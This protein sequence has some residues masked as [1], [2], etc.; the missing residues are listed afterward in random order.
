MRFNI[1]NQTNFKFLKKINLGGLKSIFFILSLLYFCIYFFE[2]IDH[3]SFDINLKRNGIYLFLSFLFY[4]IFMFI[5][6]IELYVLSLA[7]V[8]HEAQH[9]LRLLIISTFISKNYFSF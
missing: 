6:I 3:I 9:I 2:N 1:S 7:F 4:R 8:V 5:C